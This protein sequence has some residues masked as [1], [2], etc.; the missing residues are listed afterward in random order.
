MRRIIFLLIGLGYTLGVSADNTNFITKITPR[1]AMS[2]IDT[3]QIL[4]N[5]TLAMVKRTYYDPMYR[6]TLTV[7]HKHTSTLNN[8]VTLNEYDGYARPTKEWLPIAV[9]INNLTKDR[10]KEIA[11]QFHNNNSRPFVEQ[12]YSTTA[13]ANGIIKNERI[14][15]KKAGSDM[16]THRI[17]FVSRGNTSNEVKLFYVTNDGSLRCDSCYFPKRLHVAETIDEDNHTQVTY[18][19]SQE[20]VVMEKVGDLATYYVYN[21]LNQL[22]YVLPPLAVGQLDYGT[23]SDTIDCLKKYAYVYKYDERG[24]QI[25]KRVPGCEPVL[26]VY[27]K[28][29]LL[30]MSQTGNQRARGTY[31]TVYKYDALKRPIYTAEINT[32]SNNHNEFLS[33]FSGW[34]MSEHFSTEP[35][36]HPMSNTGYS[37]GYFHNRP[38]KLLTVN[39]YDNYKFLELMSDTVRNHMQFSAFKDND[40]CCVKGLLTGTRTYCLDGSGD[41]SET[42]YYYD[43]RGRE[44][45]RRSTNHL[46][47]Y[48]VLS[49][50]YDFTNNIT[51]TWSSQTTRYGTSITE[52]YQYAY[53]HA[54]RPTETMY[55]FNDESPIVLQSYH[56]DELGRVRSRHLHGGIDSVTFAYNIRDQITQIKSSGYEQ[57]YYYNQQ[58]PIANDLVSKV[59]NGNISATTWTYG[60]TTNGYIYYYDN[61]NRLKSTY[62]I[63][64]NGFGDYPY[65]ETFSY[66]AHGNIKTL[67]RWDNQDVMDYM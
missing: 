64:N 39:Y 26:M 2:S 3:S 1:E 44:I 4:Q 35:H 54:N 66:D 50:K 52:H 65:S 30:V 17:G 56:Y 58:C 46:D 41:Y 29:N 48:D 7:L 59:Y 63:L 33:S 49:T 5:P 55:Q 22:C 60:N 13:W 20:Q 21:D 43:Y 14:G 32:N 24:N 19:N 62:S 25:Y 38:T 18:T 12:N 15:A 8:L 6:P 27:D 51:D 42:V 16:G 37:R 31:W 61:M 57:K 23:Y 34:Y 53:D 45:Q 10:F 67:A 36:N 40:T 47:G 9:D 11:V 28:S